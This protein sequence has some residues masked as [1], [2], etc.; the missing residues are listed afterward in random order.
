MDNHTT[1]WREWR[2]QTVGIE[3]EVPLLNGRWRPYVN[4]DNAATTPAL[5]P[6]RDQVNRFLDWYASVHRG[7]GFKSRLATQ[8]YEDA[9]QIL[10][11][12]LGADAHE[13]LVIFTK[14]TTEALN[15]LAA[16]YPFKPSDVVITTVLEHHANLLPW[17]DRVAMV[18]IPVDERGEVQWDTLEDA[19]RAHRGRVRLVSISGASNVTGYTPPIHD[20]ARLV[21]RYDAEIVVDAAQLAPHRP[22]DMRSLDDPAHLDYL[23]FSGHKMYAP[24]GSGV[25]V[26]PRSRFQ[27][28]APLLRGGGAVKFV[29]LDAVEWEASPERDE[30]GSPNVVGAIAMATAAKTLTSWDMKQ[31]HDR[32]TYLG[33]VVVD[34]L[35][36]VP[37]LR[38]LG[39]PEA[40]G[41]QRIAVVTFVMEHVPAMMVGAILGY[42]WGIGVRAGCFCAHPYLMQ[43][44]G[45]PPD[46]MARIRDDLRRDDWSRVPSAVRVSLGLYNS[47]EE[48]RYLIQALTA[49]SRGEVHGTYRL[50]PR[51]SEYLLQGDQDDYSWAFEV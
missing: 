45:V 16:R 26:G 28:G 14:H 30:A 51:T 50:N 11:T 39:N 19:L 44:L 41:S 48:I 35:R 27:K 15:V 1:T 47:E 13:R 42:E 23:V 24:Y 17:R 38:L 25:L 10:L 5:I 29:G 49:I 7:T 4:L 40:L 8:A 33:Q 32:E 31:I 21:H 34:S 6:V 37:G 12:F 22:I 3:R 46:Q 2:S 36:T 18:Y 20:I 9:R 43:L